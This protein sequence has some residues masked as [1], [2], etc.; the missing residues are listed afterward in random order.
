LILGFNST[1][2]A[3][4]MH[5]HTLTVSF[6]CL[7]GAGGGNPGEWQMPLQPAIADIAPPPPCLAQH[8]QQPQQPQAAPMRGWDVAQV[9]MISDFWW[10]TPLAEAP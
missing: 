9:H 8:M 6:S 5:L 3:F 10:S 2:L 7:Q 1:R 4:D